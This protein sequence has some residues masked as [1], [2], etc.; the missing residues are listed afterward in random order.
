[1]NFMKVHATAIGVVKKLFARVGFTI[2]PVATNFGVLV[3]SFDLTIP[4]KTAKVSRHRIF[5][6][7][8]WVVHL[9]HYMF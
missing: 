7:P 3:K 2:P 8:R 5:H 1:M 6:V 9:K 4:L